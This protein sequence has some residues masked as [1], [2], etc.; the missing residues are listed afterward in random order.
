MKITL[1]LDNHFGFMVS[2]GRTLLEDEYF[3]IELPFMTI[4]LL[5]NSKAA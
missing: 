3:C 4:M 5:A 2:W 1:N